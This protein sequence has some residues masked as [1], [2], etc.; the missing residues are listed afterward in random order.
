MANKN[1][2]QEEA[3]T[4]RAEDIQLVRDRGKVYTWFS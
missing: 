3:E 1:F 2:M 4:C